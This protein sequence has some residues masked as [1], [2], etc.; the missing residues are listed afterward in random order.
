MCFCLCAY[1]RSTCVP[2]PQRPETALD[3]VVL[4][5]RDSALPYVG[6]GSR[7]RSSAGEASALHR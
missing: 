1:L 5:L 4:E 7:A 6:A 2:C 3:H